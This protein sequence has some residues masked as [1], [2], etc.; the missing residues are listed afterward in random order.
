MNQTELGRTGVRVGEIGLGTEHLNGQPRQTVIEVIREAVDR[1]VTYFDILWSYPD[2]LDNLGAAFAGLRDRVILTLHLGSTVT[3]DGQYQLSREVDKCAAVFAEMLARLDTDHAD[4][5]LIQWVDKD[6]DYRRIVNPGGLLEVAKSIRDDGRARFIGLSSH[7]APVAERAV[8]SGHFDVLMFPVNP[9][10]D[11][12]PGIIDH[13][14]M[15]ETVTPGQGIEPDRR[16]LYQVCAA[17]GIGLVA[18]K[19]FGGG[20]FFQLSDRQKAGLTPVRL[21]SYALSQVGVST[22]L[23]GVKNVEE[24]RAALQF[25]TATGEERDFAEAL[26]ESAWNLTGNCVYCNHC[27]PCP[28][29]IDIGG[30]L[31][32]LGVAEH[33]LSP[34]IQSQYQAL[35]A[36]ASDCTDC[37]QCAERCP[38]GVDAPALMRRAAEVLG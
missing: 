2:Y 3:D 6:D 16:R 25:L 32:L 4:A 5:V 28:S 33:G 35:P 23:P 14:A 12:L 15:P 21:L 26:A 34:E 9:A 13:Q 1:G 37:G 8:A 17:R 20:Q 31:R 36:K 29:G 24:L 27:L 11:R 7:V 22:V 18:M 38:F 19:P 30:T 10:F